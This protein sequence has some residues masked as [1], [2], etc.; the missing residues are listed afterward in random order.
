MRKL[1]LIAALLCARPAFAA[2]TIDTTVCPT[3][4]TTT[5]TGTN[6]STTNLLVASSTTFATNTTV[7]VTALG[8]FHTVTAL[9]DATHI[10]ISPATGS[11]VTTGSVTGSC[12]LEKF[13]IPVGAYTAGSSTQ[14]FPVPIKCSGTTHLYAMISDEDHGSGST[15]G[16]PTLSPGSSANYSTQWTLVGAGTGTT[17]GAFAVYHSVC[18]ANDTPTVTVTCTG[19][20]ALCHTGTGTGALETV[21]LVVGFSAVFPT[22][23]NISYSHAASG[24]TPSIALTTSSGD[25]LLMGWAD[26]TGANCTQ[27]LTSGAAILSVAEIPGPLNV[28]C[29]AGN[30]DYYPFEWTSGTTSAGSTTI[31]VTSPTNIVGSW[32]AVEIC[33]STATSCPNGAATQTGWWNWGAN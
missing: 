29:N 12:P 1:I 15:S 14:T 13:S 33:D 8:S 9:P 28:G 20:T 4:T 25:K 16:V 23:G 6:A 31:G 30:D 26:F 7:Q 24:G 17:D 5:V 18:T 2:I 27:A 3:T 19:G 22:P 11:T 21:I 10:T 32:G